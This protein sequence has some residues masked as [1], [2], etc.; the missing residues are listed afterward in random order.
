MAKDDHKPNKAEIERC[1]TYVREIVVY[2]EQDEMLKEKLGRF[3]RDIRSK[4]QAIDT[5]HNQQLDDSHADD[6]HTQSTVKTPQERIVY[7]DKIVEKRVEVPV[8]K[9]VEKIVEKKVEVTPSWA[10]SL[11]A[12]LR[13]YDLVTADTALSKILLPHDRQDVLVLITTASQWNNILRVW[14]ALASLVKETKQP[15]SSDQTQILDHCL[16]LFN[17]TLQSNQAKLISPELGTDFDFETQQKVSV[18]AVRYS[19]S[20]SQDC[21]T[22]LGIR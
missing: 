19:K 17:L 15:I 7:K 9:I 16:A 11:E 13:F 3:L 14:D 6:P 10:Q 1:L 4:S 18:V 5:S 8:E 21:T 2:V 22:L 20:S 12:E